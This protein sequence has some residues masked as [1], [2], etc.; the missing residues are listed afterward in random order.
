MKT[1][2]L[3]L[4]ALLLIA[5]MVMAACAG[6]TTEPVVEDEEPT[7]ETE[8]GT[9]GEPADEE[10]T[11]D[12]GDMDDMEEEEEQEEPAEEEMG[13]PL[14]IGVI[15]DQSGPLALFGIETLN[16]LNLG[17]DY[18][19]DGT[20][21]AGDRPVELIVR[22]DASDVEAGTAA[23]RELIEAEGVE[24]LIG[25]SSSAVALQVQQIAAENEV[26]YFAAPAASPDITGS[27][28]NEYTFRVCRNAAQDGLIIMPWA[29]ENIGTEYA[30]LAEDY[31]F[32]QATAAVFQLTTQALEGTIVP[33]GAPI[34][35]PSDTVDFSP[36][37]QQILD[38]DPDGLVLIWA[39]N[40]SAVTLFEQLE[41]QGVTGEIPFI[42]GFSSNDLTA[43]L[44]P[45]FEGSTGL[46][47]YHYTLPDTEAN[48]FLVEQHNAEYGG[49]PDLF[50]E[51][52]FAT[53]QAVV[54][55]LNETGGETGQALIEALEG[56]TFDGPKGEY[57]IRA[58]DHQALAPG[59]IVE[60]VDVDAE[61]D[62]FF[63]LVQEVPAEDIAPPVSISE[64]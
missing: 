10:A 22:D 53:A 1:R 34:F 59:Y 57:T 19:T 6:G 17:F 51:C 8:T 52:G 32:G 60:L 56:M 48:D 49:P 12:G 23:A 24:I 29:F 27:N 63:E 4:S 35:A 47:V 31:A 11:D 62:A 20:M 13:D 50:S 38:A 37:I 61:D 15:T 64:E 43:Q 26:I 28:F 25:V 14:R 9:E 16:G 44:D 55:G 54:Q 5:A 41:N 21:M 18:A 7:T 40:T 2:N 33:D 45:G 42:T 36:F 3:L 46:I 58:E 39:S 30:I